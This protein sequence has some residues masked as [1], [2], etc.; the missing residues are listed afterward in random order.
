MY[1]TALSHTSSPE[2]RM[3]VLRAQADH[4]YSIKKFELAAS[5]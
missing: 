3:T 5:L 1:D 2:N 4:Y